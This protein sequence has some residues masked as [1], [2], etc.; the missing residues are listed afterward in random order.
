MKNFGLFYKIKISSFK[1]SA[2]LKIP[3][4]TKTLIKY[5]QITPSVGLANW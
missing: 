5:L 1:N 4:Y 3:K 2:V